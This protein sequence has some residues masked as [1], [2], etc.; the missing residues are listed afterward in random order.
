MNLPS[1]EL[2][3][4]KSFETSITNTNMNMINNF[5]VGHDIELKNLETSAAKKSDS[6][7]I[8]SEP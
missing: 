6:V 4:S 1:L 2:K 3:Y 7:V 5:I 8:R